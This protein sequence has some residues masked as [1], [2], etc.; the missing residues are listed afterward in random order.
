MKQSSGLWQ[1]QCLLPDPLFE[2]YIDS[3]L[4]NSTLAATHYQFYIDILDV[5]NPATSLGFVDF[6]D[7]V[8]G[9]FGYVYYFLVQVCGHLIPYR[10]ISSILAWRKQWLAVNGK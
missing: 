1:R 7:G 8:I 5:W 4:W 2:H 3:L 10:F 6:N 9:G